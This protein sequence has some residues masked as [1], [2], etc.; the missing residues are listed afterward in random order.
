ML[1]LLVPT[2]TSSSP[3]KWVL[4]EKVGGR[5]WTALHG[6]PAQVCGSWVIFCVLTVVG[7]DAAW[8]TRKQ[9]GGHEFLPSP[10]IL[11]HASKKKATVLG[12]PLPV[13]DMLERDIWTLYKVAVSYRSPFPFDTTLSIPSISWVSDVSCALLGTG[14]KKLSGMARAGGLGVPSGAYFVSRAR[15][16]VSRCVLCDFAVAEVVGFRPCLRGRRS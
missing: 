2:D 13:T 3:W 4:E 14:K 5:G 10:L 7:V 9:N 6:M 11:P 16:N 1:S 12:R 8:N 15:S